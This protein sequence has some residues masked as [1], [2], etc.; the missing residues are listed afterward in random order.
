MTLYLKC[1]GLFCFNFRLTFIM[2]KRLLS[3]LFSGKTPSLNTAIA[4]FSDAVFLVADN[5]ADVIVDSVSITSITEWQSVIEML[6]TKHQLGGSQIAIVLGLGLYQSLLIDNPDLNADELALALPY[7]VKDLVNESPEDI[8]ADGFG[9]LHNDRMQV[10]VS[11]RQQMNKIVLACRTAGCTVGYITV[12]SVVWGEFTAENRS[13]LVVH[14]YGNG[15]LQLTAFSQHK[16]FFQRQLRGF[17]VPLVSE[18]SSD[19]QALQ[20]DSLAL[21]LQRSLDFLSAQLRDNPI[22]QLLISCDNDN[23]QQLALALSTR[24]NVTVK[25]VQ[26]PLLLLTSTGTRVAWAGLKQGFSPVIN[27]Y[28]PHLQPKRQWLSL[29]KMVASWLALVVLIGVIS[30]V[31][32]F[33][34][35]QLIPELVTNKA[36]L[37]TA[38]SQLTLTQKQ[39]LLHIVSPIK[40]Q[41]VSALEQEIIAKQSTLEAVANHDASLMVGYGQVLTQLAT[42]ASNNI[43]IERISISGNAIDLNG[44]ARTPD[45]VPSWLGTFNRYSTLAQRRFQLLNIGRDGSNQ[46][47]FTLQAQRMQEAN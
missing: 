27:F 15:N 20:L 7:L 46:I 36:Q 43:A 17:D 25:A 47:T 13:Q 31:Y 41:R 30:G 26:S 29:N 5:K 18:P 4:L 32:S 34:S 1:G 2:F 40:Q 33:K 16:L 24:L 44:V 11:T 12:E 22:S 10:F 8:V 35:R 23:N 42:A 38:Q 28:S 21:E 14:R 45:A 39:L 6:I 9:C 3:P 37:T 19:I